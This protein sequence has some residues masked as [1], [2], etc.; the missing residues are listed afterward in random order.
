M[1]QAITRLL[2]GGVDQM[3][4]DLKS[5]EMAEEE[6]QVVSHQGQSQKMLLH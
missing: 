3:P 5:G 2:F 6:W 4:G 1:F